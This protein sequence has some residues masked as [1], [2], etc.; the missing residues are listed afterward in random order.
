MRHFVGAAIHALRVVQRAGHGDPIRVFVSIVNRGLWW[1][2]S[3]G[4][5]DAAND[6]VKRHQ[7]DHARRRRDE[8]YDDLVE[9]LGRGG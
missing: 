3:E 7:H 4:D 6:L 5:I 2:V 8:P 9:R 1:H